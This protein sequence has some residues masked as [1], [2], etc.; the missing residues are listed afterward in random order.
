MW[1]HHIHKVYKL[2]EIRKYFTYR[3]NLQAQL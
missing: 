3:K 1:K 2:R